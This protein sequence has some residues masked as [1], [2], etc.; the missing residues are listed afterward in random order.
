MVTCNAEMTFALAASLTVEC[1]EQMPN[2]YP[3]MKP[4]PSPSQR[5][6][7]PKSPS[8]WEGLGVGHRMPNSYLL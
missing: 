7:R 4:T 5:E 8:P 2:W 1:L 3:K 6:G